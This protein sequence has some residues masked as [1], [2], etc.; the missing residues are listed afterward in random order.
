MNVGS[1]GNPDRPELAVPEAPRFTAKGGTEFV[2]WPEPR[3][4]AIAAVE[5]LDLDADGNPD[6]TPPPHPER[7]ALNVGMDAWLTSVV[8]LTTMP[9]VNP[10]TAPTT[11][12]APTDM[13]L[14]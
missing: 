12:A 8:R 2:V 5:S 13:R 6:Y 11:I 10:I 4:E 9:S 1:V 3:P 14:R 7:V